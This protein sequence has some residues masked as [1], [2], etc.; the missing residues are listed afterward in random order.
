MKKFIVIVVGGGLIIFSACA[1]ENKKN[2]QNVFCPMIYQPVCGE[3]KEIVGGDSYILK[4]KT[5]SNKCFLE[6]ANAKFLHKGRCQELN[7]TK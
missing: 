3:V 2:N 4:R 1:K 7:S 5:F 6:K